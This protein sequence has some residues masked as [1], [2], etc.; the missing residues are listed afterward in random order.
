M[1]DCGVDWAAVTSAGM[2]GWKTRTVNERTCL[3]H[4]KMGTGNTS[5]LMIWLRQ[6][7]KNYFL[8]NHSLWDV[9]RA[10]YQMTKKP[11]LT[12]GSLLLSGSALAGMKREKPIR[13]DLMAFNAQSKSKG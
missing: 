3:H 8:G 10:V 13:E 7:R 6:G 9:F 11:Y 5:A 1:R 2:K 4:G 12:G